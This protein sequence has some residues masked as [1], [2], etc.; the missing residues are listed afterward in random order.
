M[1]QHFAGLAMQGLLASINPKDFESTELVAAAVRIS[2]ELI[3]E[4][5]KPTP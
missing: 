3:K 2:D 4:L 1:R 5:N